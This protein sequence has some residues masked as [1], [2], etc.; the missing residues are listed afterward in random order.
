[1]IGCGLAPIASSSLALSVARAPGAPG[2]GVG[3]VG[4]LS[5]S[6]GGTKVEVPDFWSKFSP[7][8]GGVIAE[9]SGPGVDVSLL[10]CLLI[11]GSGAIGMPPSTCGASGRALGAGGVVILFRII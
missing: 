6:T 11:S 1:M 3:G 7:F 4:M 9:F 8:F 10:G 2:D 5:C